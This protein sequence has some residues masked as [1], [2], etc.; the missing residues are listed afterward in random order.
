MRMH[1]G[2]LTIESIG[3]V[4]IRWVGYADDPLIRDD[5]QDGVCCIFAWCQERYLTILLVIKY[6]FGELMILLVTEDFRVLKIFLMVKIFP[7]NVYI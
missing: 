3:M 5:L 1:D 4:M 7:I 2:S 6:S